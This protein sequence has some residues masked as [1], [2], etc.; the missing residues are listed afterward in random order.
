[1]RKPVVAAQ[2]I[3]A[4]VFATQIVQ[5]LHSLNPKFQASNRLLWL[6]SRVC[7]RP[8]RNPADRYYHEVACFIV[9]CLTLPKSDHWT[10]YHSVFSKGTIIPTS[11]QSTT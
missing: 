8:G 4:F 6:Y 3:S 2:L 5:S 1:M 10:V 11:I 9:L 7:V